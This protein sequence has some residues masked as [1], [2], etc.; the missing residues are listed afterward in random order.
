MYTVL[1]HTSKIS[2]VKKNQHLKAAIVAKRSI[3]DLFWSPVENYN[4]VEKQYGN[5]N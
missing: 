1:M 5:C 3:L 4:P 2:F